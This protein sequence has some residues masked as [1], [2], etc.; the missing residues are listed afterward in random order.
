MRE[1]KVRQEFEKGNK[2]DIL[3]KNEVFL[4]IFE[5]LE[6]QFLDAWKNSSLKDAQER[7]RIYYLYQSLKALKS[8]IE[9]V[10]ANGRLAKAQLDKII[11]NN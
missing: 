7:E 9:N 5:N 1:G 11:A 4:E 3:L 6:N 8:G 10:S 2:A